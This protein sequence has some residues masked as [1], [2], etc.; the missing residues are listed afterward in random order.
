MRKKVSTLFTY[1]K[2]HSIDPSDALNFYENSILYNLFTCE[3][4]H[5]VYL[6]KKNILKSIVS[7][8]K[9][10]HFYLLSIPYMQWHQSRGYVCRCLLHVRIKREKLNI[11]RTRAV[12]AWNYKHQVNNLLKNSQFF[13]SF[14][15]QTA[16][17]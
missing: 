11:K 13:V 14:F 10:F 9:Y 16:T 4:F 7:I 17:A 12:N 2:F 8:I 3:C 1:K 6:R 5:V 15:R